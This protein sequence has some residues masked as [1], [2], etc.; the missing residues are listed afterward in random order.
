M[1]DYNRLLQKSKQTTWNKSF[2]LRL[3]PETTPA[4]KSEMKDNASIFILTW[5]LHLAIWAATI[6]KTTEK[7]VQHKIELQ[8]FWVFLKP[9]SVYILFSVW[10]VRRRVSCLH[11]LSLI[12]GRFNKQAVYLNFRVFV[13]NCCFSNHPELSTKG[14]LIVN[15]T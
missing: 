7:Q 3:M 2:C 14:I 15:D 4:K 10:A 13:N 5:E 9:S 8:F 1:Y 6:L 12:A 11:I